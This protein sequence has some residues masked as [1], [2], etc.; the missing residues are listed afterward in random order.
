MKPV[1]V[2]GAFAAVVEPDPVVALA[3]VVGALVAPALVVGAA[4]DGPAELGVDA[5]AVG[6]LELEAPG[7]PA[8]PALRDG[9]EL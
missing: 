3:D 2:P 7:P 6:V 4:D 9:D 5:T 8:S 1:G